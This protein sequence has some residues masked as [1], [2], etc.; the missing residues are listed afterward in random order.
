[1]IRKL[2]K[3]ALGLV[4]YRPSVRLLRAERLAVDLVAL[5]FLVRTAILAFTSGFHS[6]EV[7]GVAL[8]MA[9]V[10]AQSARS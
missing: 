2:G 1:M 8:A 6:Q 9:V 4:T 7:L 5:A 10:E 3:R